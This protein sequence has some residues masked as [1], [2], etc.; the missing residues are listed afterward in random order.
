MR[1]LPVYYRVAQALSADA[2]S[3]GL[4]SADWK[5]ALQPIIGGAIMGLVCYSIARKVGV[6]EKGAKG[7]ALALGATTAI[8]QLASSWLKGWTDKAL[9]AANLAPPE[10]PT[11]VTVAPGTGTAAASG[12]PQ[13]SL[14]GLWS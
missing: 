4:S 5:A 6:D 7:V 2:P 12:N 3:S 1:N 10:T 8:G 9:A 13:G 14:K 11:A